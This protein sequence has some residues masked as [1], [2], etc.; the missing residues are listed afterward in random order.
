MGPSLRTPKWTC[1][2]E[3]HLHR[4]YILTRIFCRGVSSFVT[5]CPCGVWG[6]GLTVCLLY[7]GL[8]K[9]IL[10]K[11][12]CKFDSMKNSFSLLCKIYI[13]RTYWYMY[14][15]SSISVCFIFAFTSHIASWLGYFVLP[16]P[17]DAIISLPIWTVLVLC[18]SI[19]LHLLSFYSWVRS[20]QLEMT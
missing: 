12:I 3:T 1:C 17:I 10:N 4:V 7:V 14:C 16:C 15:H 6:R 8:S 19:L 5:R 20:S 2:Y 18:P 9:S 11:L 13:Q